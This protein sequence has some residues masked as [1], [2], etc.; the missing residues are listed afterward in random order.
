MNKVGWKKMLLPVGY[1]QQ[2]RGGNEALNDNMK[3]N[4]RHIVKQKN[5]LSINFKFRDAAII[6]FSYKSNPD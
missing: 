3:S 2:L 1:G 4:F 5:R 6:K